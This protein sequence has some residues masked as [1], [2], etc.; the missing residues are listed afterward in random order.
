MFYYRVI[1]PNDTDRMT[2]SVDPDQTAPEHSDLG[3]ESVDPDQNAP[4]QSDLGLHYLHR[5]DCPKT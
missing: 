1:G 3:L 2:D 5:P 4:E